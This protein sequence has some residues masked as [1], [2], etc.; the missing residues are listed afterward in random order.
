MN[1]KPVSGHDVSAAMA[2]QACHTT[3]QAQPETN[4]NRGV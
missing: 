2:I 1:A 3:G 4:N